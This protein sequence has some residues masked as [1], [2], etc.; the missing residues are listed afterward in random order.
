ML[1]TKDGEDAA[2]WSFES[3]IQHWIRK[4]SK[5]V[6]VPSMRWRRRETRYPESRRVQRS[7]DRR[8]IEHG[9]HQ[10]E[11]MERNWRMEEGYAYGTVADDRP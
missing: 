1:Q 4:H 6:Y 11:G 10:R 5:A 9:G 7:D 3:I 8:E 2:S